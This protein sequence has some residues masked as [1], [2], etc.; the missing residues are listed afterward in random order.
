MLMKNNM[1]LMKI[2]KIIKYFILSDLAFWT[3]WGLVTPIFA[4]FITQHMAGTALTV[5]IATAIYWITKAILEYPFGLFLDHHQG[6]NDDY[7]FLVCGT[8]IA[9]LVPLGYFFATTEWH[10]Y[11]LQFF[12]GIG[13]ATSITGWRAIFTRN[14]DKGHEAADWS[15]DDAVIGFGTGLSGVTSGFLVY[16]FGFMP[17]FIIASMMGLIG[18]LFLFCLRKDILRWKK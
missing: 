8:F 18:V 3:G 6:D 14:I 13:M 4:I 2:N 17:S 15:L 1:H 16:K 7:L 11:V 10:I 9:S 5:G 12:Y